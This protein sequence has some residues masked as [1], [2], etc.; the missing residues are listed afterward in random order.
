MNLL[1]APTLVM[2]GVV[3]IGA[4]AVY[5]LVKTKTE[6]VKPGP[7][8]QELALLGDPL[9]LAANRYYRARIQ[10]SSFLGN[11]SRAQVAQSLQALGFS[12]VTVY[13][14]ERD[15]PSDWPASAKGSGIWFQAQ[16]RQ[17]TISLPR[18][19]DL[20]MIW[21]AK[22]PAAATYVA[23]AGMYRSYSYR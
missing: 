14:T 11:Q 18:P 20:D 19:Q 10:P 5:R 12:D 4:F 6:D 7:D 23:T 22:P 1:S 21:I 8:G 9:K 17:P 13:M 3:G 16:W 2:A 15:L